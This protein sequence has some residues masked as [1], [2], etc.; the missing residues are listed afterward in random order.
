MLNILYLNRRDSIS[1]AADEVIDEINA[2][3]DETYKPLKHKSKLKKKNQQDIIKLM[4]NSISN[5][6]KCYSTKNINFNN[7][8]EAKGIISISNE[9][10]FYRKETIKCGIRAGECL[11]KGQCPF[12]M[13]ALAPTD[14]QDIGVNL[15][16]S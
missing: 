1:K 13:G 6:N 16:V 5:G 8:N 3:D 15:K 10:E 9:L 12:S 4:K 14:L 7:L 11:Y 2:S